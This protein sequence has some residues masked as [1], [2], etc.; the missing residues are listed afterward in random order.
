MS[1]LCLHIFVKLGKA[2]VVIFFWFNS[3]GKFILDPKLLYLNFTRL[4][5]IFKAEILLTKHRQQSA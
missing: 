3:F 4:E 2:Q 1:H 5:Y